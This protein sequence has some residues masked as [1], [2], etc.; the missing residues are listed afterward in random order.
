M[1]NELENNRT[2]DMVEITMLSDREKELKTELR[3][4]HNEL[5]AEKDRCDRYL[6]QVRIFTARI[7]SFA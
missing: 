7:Q 3:T 5:I 2:E 4:A 6:A 1:R